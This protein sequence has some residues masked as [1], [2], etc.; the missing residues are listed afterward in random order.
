MSFVNIF[1][2]TNLKILNIVLWNGIWKKKTSF[3]RSNRTYHNKKE[4]KVFVMLYSLGSQLFCLSFL[5]FI[6]KINMIN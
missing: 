6:L 1:F 2:S 4:S 5:Y 3:L